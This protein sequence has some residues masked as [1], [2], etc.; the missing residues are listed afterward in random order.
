MPPRS[1]RRTAQSRRRVRGL[2]ILER[3]GNRL[4]EPMIIFVWLIGL[5]IVLSVLLSLA[6]ASVIHPDTGEDTAVRSLLSGE[7]V[8]F[9]LEDTVNNFVGFA[10]VGVVLTMM[11][12]IGLADKTGLLQALIRGTM[13]RTPAWLLPYAVFFVANNAVIA[14]DAAFLIVPPLA[15]MVYRT[16][17]RHPLVGI[18]S[19]F[20]G[21]SSGYASGFLITAN[22]P[23]LAGISTEAARILGEGGPEVTAVDNYYF[24]IA[25]MIGCTLV[26]GTIT[27]FVIEPRLGLYEGEHTVSAEPLTTSEK[28][29]LSAAGLFTI[30]YIGAV[31]AA[32][33]VPG[34]PVRGEGGDVTTSPL[35]SGVVPLLF[36]YFALVG[37][38]YGVTAKVLSG[39]RDVVEKFADAIG[40]MR[41]FIVVIFFIAQFSAYFTWTNIGLWISVNG[42]DLLLAMD[43]TGFGVLLGVIV[44]SA[45]LTLLITS[46]SGLWAILAPIFVPMLMQVGFHPAAVQMAYRIGDGSTS[47]ITPLMPYMV[48][49]LGFMREW[50]REA[51]LGHILSNTV[52][53][54][55]GVFLVQTGLFLAFYAFGIPIGPGIDFHLE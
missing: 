27:R 30:V 37:L 28:R 10:P 19:A 11:L 17:G 38:V 33:L 12:G 2:D 40:S 31:I 34:S 49:I 48:V 8:R 54:A 13:L 14:T 15:A 39:G 47:M 18:I 4:P 45:L 50:D 42:A 7:G 5:V 21:S 16:L 24:M 44:V 52:P 25:S 35:L 51:K 29:G 41:F 53:Y 26:G 3:L 6:G 1:T 36:I 22:E 43:A 9:I 23:M 46:G 20:A 32:A 55:I